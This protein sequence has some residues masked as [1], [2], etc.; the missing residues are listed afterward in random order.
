MLI[1]CIALQVK[2]ELSDTESDY[3]RLQNTPFVT[4][5][6]VTLDDLIW[7]ADMSNSRSF[8]IPKDLGE[9]ALRTALPT[10]T[11]SRCQCITC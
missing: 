11:N 9:L 10:V 6:D 7:A 3:D 4:S 5:L 1:C 8:A 2:Q